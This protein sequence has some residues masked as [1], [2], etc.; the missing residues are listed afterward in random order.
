MIFHSHRLEDEVKELVRQMMN[1][2]CLTANQKIKFGA[3]ATRVVSNIEIKRAL[4]R[5]ENEFKPALQS[6][7]DEFKGIKGA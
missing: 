1:D 5:I 3:I 7:M 4:E 6:A 2:A